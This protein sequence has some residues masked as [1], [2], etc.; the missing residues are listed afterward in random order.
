[1]ADNRKYAQVQY[2]TLAGSGASLGAAS[3]ILNSFQDIDGNNLAMTNFGTKGYATIEPGSRDQEEQISFTGVTQ[4]VNGTATLTGVSNVGFLYPYTE[5][6]NL[7]KSHAGNTKF[8]ITNT[9]GFYDN[10][11]NKNNDETIANGSLWVFPSTTANSRPQLLA[12]VDATLNQELITFGQLAR[13]SFAGTVD[14]SIVQKG[15]VEGGTQA[16]VD[17]ATQFGA[18]GA[19][20]YINPSRVAFSATTRGLPEMATQAEYDARTTIGATGANLA[21]NPSSTRTVRMHDYVASATGTDSYAIA[22][23]PVIAAYTVGDVFI[24][25]AD[26]AN[27]GTASL[28]VNAVG[29]ITIVKGVSTVLSTGDIAVN[30]IVTVIYDGTNMQMTSLPASALPTSSYIAGEAITAGECIALVNDCFQNSRQNLATSSQ[31][32]VMGDTGTRERKGLSFTP[33]GNFTADRILVQAAV[34]GAPGDNFFITIETDTAGSPSGAPIANGTSNNVAG[35][36]LTTSYGNTVVQFAAAFTLVSGTKYWIVIQRT[37]A[38]D[39]ANYYNFDIGGSGAAYASFIAKS[40][41]GAAWNSNSDIFYFDM[42][43]GVTTLNSISAYRTVD[44]FNPLKNFIGIATTTVAAGAT[45]SVQDSGVNSNQTG[46]TPNVKYYIAGVL[47]AITSATGSTG[48]TVGLAISTTQLLIR[49]GLLYSNGTVTRAGNAASSVV[50]INHML[51]KVPDKIRFSAVWENQAG[52]NDDSMS[53]S[54][55]PY[56]GGDSCVYW[57]NG[58]DA[59]TGASTNAVEIRN[60]AGNSQIATVNL[61]DQNFIQLNFTLTGGMAAP[62]MYILWEAEVA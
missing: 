43:L 15:I 56:F 9:S 13:T 8:I 33:R 34:T 14:A 5:T 61:V 41:D 44:T 53:F 7:A 31:R 36:G 21:V 6:A 12:D 54:S 19:E 49:R 4:N 40:F 18:T 37:G 17:A 35:G 24:F 47:G 60:N 11:T 20:L 58:A 29:P 26:V 59:Q 48:G 57:T 50:L 51:G 23:T 38:Q 42:Q 52:V 39:A 22:L 25:K 55:L 45:L 27:T 30:Q 62:N 10:F 2:F 46:L 28:N 1:M 3:I 32:T 16:E